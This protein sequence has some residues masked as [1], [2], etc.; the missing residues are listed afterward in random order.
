[1][2]LESTARKN[3]SEP[4]SSYASA[5]RRERR[6][7]EVNRSCRRKFQAV[8]SRSFVDGRAVGLAEADLAERLQDSPQIQIPR[9]TGGTIAVDDADSNPRAAFHSRSDPPRRAGGRKI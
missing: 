4:T 5:E 7:R 6:E 1:M 8:Y 2:V 3:L 9:I